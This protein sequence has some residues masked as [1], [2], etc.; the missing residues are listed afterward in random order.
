VR[1]TIEM[2]R[3]PIL[4]VMKRRKRVGDIFRDVLSRHNLADAFDEREIQIR[5]KLIVENTGNQKRLSNAIFD[6]MFPKE[7][8]PSYLL[9]YTKVSTLQAIA[10]SG[11]LHLYNIRKRI[12]QGE[13]NTFS[14]KHSPGIPR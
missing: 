5:P 12:G 11:T 2:T 14:I 9:H 4:A 6:A 13:L 3:A 7:S 10:A 8:T 1:E